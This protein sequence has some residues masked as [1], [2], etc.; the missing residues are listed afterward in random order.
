MI[1]VIAIGVGLI[2]A[3]FI[4]R[5]QPPRALFSGVGPYFWLITP[6]VAL[7]TWMV[8]VGWDD[9]TPGVKAGIAGF[10]AFMWVLVLAI[11]SPTRFRW[12]P[13]VVTGFVASAYIWYLG[14]EGWHAIQTRSLEGTRSG[15]S[16]VQALAG[17]IF[18]GLPSLWFTFA[19]RS[20]ATL[21]EDTSGEGGA[22]TRHAGSDV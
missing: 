14:V 7:F 19:G 16:V 6:C 4:R 9:N 20:R 22:A 10:V 18:F 17:F 2:L 15:T 21:L 13:R 8:L 1:P 12:A 5:E 11:A 3:W